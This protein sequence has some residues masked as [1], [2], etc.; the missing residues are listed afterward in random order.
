MR[1]FLL[2]ALALGLAACDSTEPDVPAAARALYV[3]NQGNFSD[4]NGSVTRYDLEGGA[5]TQDAVPSVDGLVQ[6]LVSLGDRLVVLLNYD[7]S[8][9]TGRGRVDVVDL[10]TGALEAQAAVGTPRALAGRTFTGDGPTEVYVSNL[11]AGTVTPLSLIDGTVGAPVAVGGDYPETNP[12]GVVSVGSRTFVANSGFGAGTTLTVLDTDSGDVIDTVENICTGPRT[13]LGDRGGEVWVICTGATD[14]STGAVTAPGQVV[15]LSSSGT[16]RQRYTAEGE[17]LGSATF[18]VDAVYAP[19]S[20]EVYVIGTGAVL[21]FDAETNGLEARIE[22]PGAPIG[23]VAYDADAER[24]YLGRADAQ[25]PF[26]ADGA[27]T[28]HDRA[29]AQVGRFAAG[30][31]PAAMAFGTAR[32]DLED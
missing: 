11:Y 16:V 17:T 23:A 32:R 1:R 30:I 7:D 8:F 4:N 20:D 25:S 14:F 12:E 31:A 28:I 26:A 6:N 29:G 10:E 9:T 24:L 22:A 27:V 18:G 21:R 5:V 3:G 13:L 2:L 19:E 15:V